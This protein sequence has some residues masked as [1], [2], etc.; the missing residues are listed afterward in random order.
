MNH[1]ACLQASVCCSFLIENTYW[2]CQ[3]GLSKKNGMS[4]VLTITT[5][6]ANLSQQKNAGPLD[7]GAA[8][9]VCCDLEEWS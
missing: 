1:I 5:P 4:N 7:V 8:G 6:G 9:N 3:P 2:N